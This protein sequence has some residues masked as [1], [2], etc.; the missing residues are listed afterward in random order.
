MSEVVTLSKRGRIGVVAVENPPVNAISQAVRQGLVDCI[1]A[2]DA[3]DEIAALVLHCEGRTFMA[4]AD[5]REFGKPLAPPS[6][7]GL[8]NAIEQLSKPVVA[9]LHGTALG[10]GFEISLGCH[11]RCAAPSARMG[12]P[13]VLLGLIPGAGGT[14]RAPRLMPV[15]DALDL[16][17][18][19]SPMG[20]PDALAKGLVDEIVEGDLLDGAIARAERQLDENAPIRRVSEIA[21]APDS[22]EPGFFDAYRKSMARR[23]RGYFAPERIVESV[24]NVF[25]M[26][27][28]EGATREQELFSECM[29]SPQSAGMRHVFFAEREVAKI[30]DIPKDTA[31]RPV[32]K[33]AVIGAGTMGGGIAMNFANAGIP[34]T[35]LEVESAALDRGL[36]VVRA[37]YENTMRK[38]RLSEDDVERRMGL[39]TGTLEFADLAG[40][41]L[42]VE[43]VFENMDL[44]KQVFTRLEQV[45]KA[46]AI[47]ASNTSTL[48]V[49]EIAAITNR[50]GDILGLH[51]FSPAN[52]MRLL[53][54]VRGEKTSPE[55]LATCM[56]VARAIR[57]IGV[58][59]G[60]C[61]GFIG[62]RMLE[63]Y[64]REC[65]F[66]LLEGASAEQIDEVIYD[67]GLPMGP[68][69]MMD[70]AGQDVGA[71]IR[72]ER[73]ATGD[74]PDDERYGLVSDKI[75]ALGRHGQKTRAGVYKYESG[76]R[77][78]IPDPEVV[79]LIET[80]AARLGIERREFGHD[81]ILERC[82]YPLINEAALILE[83]GIAL[84]PGD[85][86]IV[87]IN[88]YGFPPYR[89]GPMFYADTVGLKTIHERMLAYG[90]TLGNEHGYWTPAPL[91][92]E[93]AASGRDFSEWA[94]TRSS[95]N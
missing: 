46:G 52:V 5:I 24:E 71:K 50:P 78:P 18:S 48:D 83:E 95:S 79:A 69:A 84:R 93:L 42:V 58:V 49:D 89:G 28:S 51:F 66:M 20:A 21:L 7:P 56:Q 81:E 77:A 32:E 68:N 33:A 31:T 94:R 37:N 11:F 3:D 19:G 55:V 54:V 17:I 76:S 9:A 29:D 27:F 87:W 30:P 91:L 34:V 61:Y 12:F 6:L 70:L 47:I 82:L 10:G 92:E 36:G 63:G 1:Q 38:G 72:V 85:I 4:G 88:G 22:V 67:F 57:K 44:K 62:N 8:I 41:D 35:V 74:L 15:A 16:M 26:A 80:E 90:E 73:R 43:A 65:G 2:A 25:R 40:A 45:C 59:S 53:E 23:T 75:V 64:L 13:E 39:I 86:D 60:V 14:Q